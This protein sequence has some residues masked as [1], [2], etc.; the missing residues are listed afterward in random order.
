MSYKLLFSYFNS[1]VKYLDSILMVPTKIIQNNLL[2]KMDSLPNNLKTPLSFSTILLFIIFI[3]ISYANNLICNI[4]GI[5]YPIMY[6]FS[7]FNEKPINIDKLTI[8]NKYWILFGLIT[9]TDTFFGF[10]LHIIPGY[11]Y[12]KIALIY[13]LIRNDFVLANVG[14][15]MVQSFYPQASAQNLIEKISEKIETSV[16]TI[17]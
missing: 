7:I 9:L 17:Q 16:D 14:F 8:M 2:L 11:F 10:L 5:L 12:F 3:I 13:V 4:I 1:V 15:K 6:N